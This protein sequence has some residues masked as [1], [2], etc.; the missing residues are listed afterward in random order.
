MNLNLIEKRFKVYNNWS[1]PK[2]QVRILRREDNYDITNYP[3]NIL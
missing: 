2:K 1:T 3:D